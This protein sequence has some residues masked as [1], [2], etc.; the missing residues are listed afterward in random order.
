MN[1]YRVF[2]S[3]RFKKDYKK[4]IHRKKHLEAIQETILLLSENGHEAIPENKRPHKL[5]GNYIGCWEC[6]AMP[7]LLVIWEQDEDLKE[8][9]LIRVGSHSELF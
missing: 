9:V 5:T 1:N 4:F 3:S 7:D 6:H 8:I 2:P